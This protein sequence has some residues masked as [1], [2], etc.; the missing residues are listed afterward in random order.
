[1][2]ENQQPDDSGES[3]LQAVP[4]GGINRPHSSALRTQKDDPDKFL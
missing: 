3:S 2:Q 4:E 1:M